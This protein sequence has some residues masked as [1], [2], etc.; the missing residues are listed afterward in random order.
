MSVHTKRPRIKPKTKRKK[1]TRNVSWRTVLKDVIVDGEGAA[2]LRGARHKEGYTQK[3]LAAKLGKS[4]LQQHISEMERGLRTISVSM[5]KKL[6]KV[7]KI[8]YKVFL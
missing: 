3:Q 5:A 1:K 2:A 6:G 7:L 4:I 8:N